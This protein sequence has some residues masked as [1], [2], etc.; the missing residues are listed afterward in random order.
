M[1]LVDAETVV[2]KDVTS[3]LAKELLMLKEFDL[4]SEFG[5]CIGM[6]KFLCYLQKFKSLLSGAGYFNLSDWPFFF[7]LILADILPL[8]N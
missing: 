8:L 4:D 3:D 1:F 5:P 2:A 6:L 7:S